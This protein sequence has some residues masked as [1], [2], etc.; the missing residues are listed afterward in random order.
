MATHLRGVTGVL[1]IRMCGS[2]WTEG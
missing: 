1:E 2:D